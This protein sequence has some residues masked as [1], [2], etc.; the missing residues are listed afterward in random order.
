MAM[1]D[2][3]SASYQRVARLIEGQ[4]SFIILSH[5]NPDFDAYGS[6]CALA[7]MLTKAGR[8][9]LCVNQDGLVQ[10]YKTAVAPVTV[11]SDFPT[12]SG[13]DSSTVLITCDCG[14]KKR[15]GDRLIPELARFKTIVNIDH[16]ASNDNFGTLNVVD[17]EAS[18][19]S[20]M[21]FLLIKQLGWQ[22]DSTAANMLLCGMV[23]DTGSFRYSS[24]SAQTFAVAAELCRAGASPFN[25]AT[26]LY[27][28]NSLA[29]VK[30]QS[31]ALL[32][33]EYFKDGAIAVT[34]VPFA[35]KS[36]LGATSDDTEGLVEKLRDISGVVLAATIIEDRSPE[37]GTFF[38]VS[39]RS[40]RPDLNLSKLAGAFGGGGHR[41]AA[42]FR[43]RKGF[44]ELHQRL[45]AGLE[46][47][48]GE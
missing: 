46:E 24:T 15:V 23:A 47:L 12:A 3:L 29:S 40:K 9:A 13:A 8:S 14:D 2:G 32:E 37:F 19:T 41:S 11:L 36:E 28:S 16:H 42:G 48:L 17:P 7:H 6:S 34:F 43:W 4:Q 26:E 44:Q 20:E 31:R 39:T 25:V 5:Y 30:L 38:R 1:A 22:L 18:S 10:R 45:V 27:S 21:I 33:T 35:L